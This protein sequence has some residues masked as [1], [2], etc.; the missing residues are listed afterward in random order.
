MT[1]YTYIQY[2]DDVIN[3][4]IPTGHLVKLAVQRHLNDLETGHRRGLYFDKKAAEDVID[5]ISS[6]NHYA[7]KLAGLKI[8]LEPWQQFILAMLFGW[9]RS[10]G[11][12]RFRTGYLSVARKNGKTTLSLAIALYLMLVDGVPKAE[13]YFVSSTKSASAF[14]LSRAIYMVNRPKFVCKNHTITDTWTKSQLISIGAKTRPTSLDGINPHG[15]VIDEL[16]NH[17]SSRLWDVS[18]FAM[19]NNKQA[20]LFATTTAGIYRNTFC[21]S[22]DDYISMILDGTVEDDSCFGIIYTL[23]DKDDDLYE[24][25]WIKSNPNLGVSI[26]KLHLRDMR[27][28][29]ELFKVKHLNIWPD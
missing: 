2:I 28:E 6:L 19:G 18:R 20:L 25:N 22:I 9:K 5:F 13:N 27:K 16:Y 7:G 24:A 15:V 3:K 17:Q 1:N 21:R 8:K 10:D 12:R 23:D 14:Y 11:T 29:R 4:K 26:Q